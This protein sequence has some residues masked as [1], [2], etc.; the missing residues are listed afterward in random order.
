MNKKTKMWLGVGILG[1]GVGILGVAAYYLLVKKDK[2][3]KAN[4]SGKSN[5][6]CVFMEGGELVDGKTSSYDSS[7]CI[8]ST[9]KRGSV[10]SEHNQEWKSKI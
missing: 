1:V 7:V 9:G 6:P 10:Y 4:A 3:T 5:S 2:N 8:S